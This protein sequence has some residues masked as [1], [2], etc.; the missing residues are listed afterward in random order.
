M[1]DPFGAVSYAA[2]ALV[3]ILTIPPVWRFAKL[4]RRGKPAKLDRDAIYEDKDGAATAD[5]MK[6]YSTTKQ[7]TAVF[8]ACA[9][10]LAAALALV[11]V[12]TVYHL[13]DITRIWLL[14]W[15][16][17]LAL[18]QVFDTF[19]ESRVVERSRRGI[20][21]S[22]S[23]GLIA[24]LAAILL[25][26]QEFSGKREV[27]LAVTLLV[28]ITAA[29]TIIVAFGLI[30]LRPDVFTPTGKLVERQLTSSFWTRYSYNWSSDLLDL[31]ATKLIELEDLPAM[32]AN[33][34]ATD[35][36]KAF[37]SIVLKPSV[38]LWLRIFWAYRRQ[39]AFQW[40]IV[41]ASSIV[42]A[43]PPLAMYQLLKYLEARTEFT[44]IDPRAW[45]CVGALLVATLL[46]TCFD[47]RVNWLMWSEL[48]VP[49]RASLTALIY[50]KMMKIKDCK[51]PPKVEI[52]KTGDKKDTN[53][54]TKK[55]DSAPSPSGR[56]KKDGGPKK[57]EDQNQQDIIN[58]FAVD[59][60]SVG[61]FGA[62]NQFYVSFASSFV[63]SIV[64]LWLLV[65]WESLAAGM[66]AIILA[67]PFNKIFASRYGFLQ[68]ELMK[69][70]DKKTKV[71]SE[72]LQGIRQIKFSALESEWSGKIN[73]VRD[74]ELKLLWQTKLISLYMSLCGNIAPVF[75]TVFALATYA[76]IYGNLL[77]SVAFTAL[78]VFI[79][80]EGVLKMVPFLF[81]MGSNAKVSCDRIDT[82]LRSPEKPQNIYPGDCINF[83]KVSVSFPSKSETLHEVAEDEDAEAQETRANRFILRD[84][85]L[86]FPNNVLSLILGPT[87]S[88]K[89][90]LLAAILGEVDVL[91]GNITAPHPPPADQRFDSKATAADWI[92]PAAVAYVAQ[93]PWIENA[94]IKANILFGLPF[95]EIR[96]N[97]VLKA[98]ALAKD[99]ELFDD[100]DLTEVGAQGISLSGGQK[101]RLTLARALYSRAGILILDDVFSALD[102]HV[103][104]QIY[105]NALNGELAEGRT[106]ILATHHASLCLPRAE[107][108]VCL[109]A[110]G[111]LEHAGHVRDL[112]GNPDF[113]EILKAAE[114][115]IGR[116]DQGPLESAVTDIANNGSPT[117]PNKSPP[118]KLVEDEKRETGSVK[119]SVYVAYLKATGGIPFWGF[120]FMFFVVAQ[121]LTL[122]R[123]WWIKIWTSSYEHIQEGTTTYLYSTQTP[124]GGMNAFSLPASQILGNEPVFGN[125]DFLSSFPVTDLMAITPA[126]IILGNPNSPPVASNAMHSVIPKTSK[127]SA[128]SFPID[129]KDRTIGFYLLGYIIISLVST[130]VDLGRLFVIY[131]GSLRASRT[132]FR[133]MTD[134][135]LRTPLRWLDTVPTGR[136]LNRFTADFQSVDSQL[137]SNFAQV[138]S[139]F[140]SIA[141]I[142]VAAFIVSPYIILL[143]LVLLAICARIA[144]RY[145]RGARSI[146]RLESIQKSPMISHF[147]ASLQGLSTIRAFANTE[148][149]ES[150]MNN[151]IDSFT[152]ATW[153]N[154]LFN[155]WVGFRMAM[156]GSV[157]STLVA[158]FV[159]STSG[160]DAAL[161]G[162][163]LAF[164]M[165]YR[166]T[167]NVTLRLVAATEL[168]MNAAER[169]FEY[170]N[171]NVEDHGG[172]AVRASWPEKGGLEVKDLEVG[173]AEG[174]PNIL[175]GLT[176]HAESNQ[177]IGVV[178]RTGAG[179]STLSLALFRFLEARAGTIVIDGVDISKVKLHD[180]RTRL[181]IIPQ[182]PV[183]FSGTI[184]SNLD[185]FDEF[186]DVQLKQA[187]QR[188]HLIPS[189]D[190]TPVPEAATPVETTSTDASIATSTTAADPSTA[191]RENV[192]IFLSLES[193]ISS[194][195]GN[196]SQGQ[197]QL[198]CLARAILSRPKLLLLDEA[199]SAVDK[200]TDTLI[201]RSIR[202]EF[203]NTTLLVIAHRLSTVMDF[204]RILVM[205]DGVAAEFGSPRELLGLD[206]GVFKDMVEHSGEKDELSKTVGLP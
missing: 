169:I 72:A 151:L 13:P 172:M 21:N 52:E 114:A 17:V 89:S 173:Y 61:V 46:E 195:G 20:F 154:W 39:I 16:W 43:G 168:D 178:G 146:K 150:R 79:Q 177:R 73:N 180:L 110:A 189:A 22:I 205:K 92:I 137:S 202:E 19:R 60:N 148:A 86:K 87:G 88:G 145:I 70:R 37:Q 107:Y 58:M 81:M 174:L 38:S 161:G 157:F 109:S 102:A 131:R 80:L 166:R 129:V 163:A 6:N 176:F 201:Q 59:A 71:I 62:I 91:E 18:L 95:D 5:S 121:G 130:M 56:A 14:F 34:R 45:L 152:S 66:F 132:V 74:D 3:G 124:I 25:S 111:T 139:S 193:P 28:Q 140:L 149:F 171:L 63:V 126:A 11:V 118:K 48:G 203:T 128:Q 185:P 192:N 51:E 54:H 156:T 50:E 65:G 96:Y 108:A 184:R 162:F 77:P 90:L 186:S 49:I 35:A 120:V 41:I 190:N 27:A 97:K 99:L 165:N 85:T 123:S 183:L 47:Y 204:D 194:A 104:K 170:S 147:T 82:F 105:D 206:D 135:V 198:L 134:K 133:D 4:I 64:F 40:F 83:D 164:A 144:L 117:K 53:G 2:P 113:E 200:K 153:H 125:L 33:V 142:M 181:A 32:D 10:G 103:G 7:F 101:W 30:D 119:R 75:L 68:K 23:F 78:G 94:T 158:A 26:E 106:R 191:N 112:K 12:A 15:S 138:G 100:G 167:V 69:S 36:K 196:L 136:I 122:G 44:P 57:S 1:D 84:V 76:Y 115:E 159:V 197:K 42:D 179:K 9:L 160:I 31:A 116:N 175:K 67:F 24:I 155:T 143:A 98:C 55:P 141:G 8:V 182:D 188:V 93:T 127:V 187:L 199:T 29:L